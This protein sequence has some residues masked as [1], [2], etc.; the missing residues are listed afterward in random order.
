[1]NIARRTDPT[2][3]LLE[4][5]ARRI[6][7]GA[8]T[9]DDLLLDIESGHLRRF[10]NNGAE[11]P[12]VMPTQVERTVPFARGLTIVTYT[13]SQVLFL[14]NGFGVTCAM[15]AMFRAEVQDKH[16]QVFVFEGPESQ[17]CLLE[18]EVKGRN[19][20]AGL[21]L[22][23]LLEARDQ[24]LAMLPA[25]DQAG[26]GELYLAAQALTL[27]ALWQAPSHSGLLSLADP[28]DANV[29]DPEDGLDEAVWRVLCEAITAANHLNA[30][31]FTVIRRLAP[32]VSPN[33][34]PGAYLLFMLRY[35]VAD[36]VGHRPSVDDLRHLTEQ[37]ATAFGK[38]IRQESHLEDALLMAFNLESKL[39]PGL[40][41]VAAAAALGVLLRDPMLQLRLMRPALASWWERRPN[42]IQASS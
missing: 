29:A 31:G 25:R 30:V 8:L 24:E 9:P 3:R 16:R 41:T 27:D 34:Q 37:H 21:F 32:L 12:L 13:Q 20:W 39:T 23:R 15:T 7:G 38:V 2:G 18:I 19:N 6:A 4:R 1:M 36:V 5:L 10:R 42:A 22:E 40:F 26:W 17:L 14:A 33:A 28:A 11:K 35:Q